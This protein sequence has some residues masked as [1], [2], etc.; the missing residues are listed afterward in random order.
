MTRLFRPVALAVALILMSCEIAAD[1]SYHIGNSL[2]WDMYVVGLQQM[3]QS[4]GGSL[5]PGYHIRSSQSLS[6]MLS[7]PGDVTV[8]SP[9]TWPTALPGQPWN[10]LTFQPY[11]GSTAASTLQTDITAAQTF[12]DLVA[13][14]SSPRP[15]IFIYEAWPAQA[16]FSGNYGAYWNQTV[17]NT[18]NQQTILARQYFD[19]LFQRLTALYGDTATIRVIPVG[20]VLARIDQL[21]AAGQFQG[22]S[23]IADFYRD[24]HHMG[25]AGRFTAAITALA[26]MYRRKPA[27]TSFAIYQQF[28]D[29]SV[30]LTPQVAAQLESIVWDVLTSDS[31]RTGI[32]PI[33]LNPGSL[34]FRSTPIGARDQPQTVAISNLTSAPVAIDAIAV[35]Q[36]FLQTGSTCGTS[37]AANSECT[38]TVTSAPAVA[39]ALSG[40]LTIR[41]AGVTYSV[42]LAGNAPVTAT[43]SADT[44]AATVGQ[45]VTLTWNSSPGATCQAQS[46]GQ[47]GQWIGSVA[48]SGTRTFAESTAASIEYSLHCS[49]SGVADIS[50]SASVVWSWPP[51]DVTLSATPTTV[52]AGQPTS[53]TWSSSGATDCNASGGGS[54]DGW[55]GAKPTGGTQSVTESVGAGN[56][57][58]TLGCSSSLSGLSK[59]ASVTVVQ[60]APRKSGGGGATDLV[61]LIVAGL[62]CSR[63]SRRSARGT[64]SW[65]TV[66]S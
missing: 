33:S 65:L 41:S 58:F 26:T 5:T 31:A 55:S 14:T 38:V 43:I 24:T 60:N 52:E 49:A 51:V 39:G 29:G 10:F 56:L 62:L 13:G 19:A 30:I 45:P 37:L 27:G 35:T 57:T 8:D 6:Y 20:D 7:N 3:A 32:Y 40:M 61:S 17:P 46:S 18:L 44:T 59:S 25:S 11:P 2:T 16:S 66:A 1:T 4:F 22:A 50:V 12:I 47:G 48:P 54:G 36:N 64:A 53:I 63:R 23:S 42:S 28:N 9:A 34:S 21:I 15:V